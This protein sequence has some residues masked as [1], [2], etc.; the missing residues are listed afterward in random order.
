M[1]A[2]DFRMDL[3]EHHRQTHRRAFRLSSATSLPIRLL[4]SL[5]HPPQLLHA[6][7]DFLL[8]TLQ[9][10][11]D[12]LR[13][14]VVNFFVDDFFVTVYRQVLTLLDDVRLRH[15][16]TLGGASVLPLGLFAE[17]KATKNVGQVVLGVLV[18][19]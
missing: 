11:Q 1:R 19:R 9:L 14:A 6:L 17:R 16:K 10:I 5:Q 13:G 7:G 4:V 2:A 12:R 3:S 18:L 8:N 15:A